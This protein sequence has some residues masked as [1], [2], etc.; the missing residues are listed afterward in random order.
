MQGCRHA[1]DVILRELRAVVGDDDRKPL[2]RALDADRDPRICGACRGEGVDGILHEVV[3]RDADF[4]GRDAHGELFGRCGR[5][6]ND[7]ALKARVALEEPD[8]LVDHVSQIGRDAVNG[9]GPCIESHALDNVRHSFGLRVDLREDALGHFGRERARGAEVAQS[10]NVGEDGADGLADFVREHRAQLS[11]KPDAQKSPVAFVRLLSLA[12]Q[13]PLVFQRPLELA[14][15]DPDHAAQKGRKAEAEEGCGEG[16]GGEEP[17]LL[18]EVAEA[19]FVHDV[20][21]ARA[22]GLE[23]SVGALEVGGDAPA[24]AVG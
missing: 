15:P 18:D 21:D 1:G 16:H 23:D 3:Q 5:L 8:R 24:H 14:G 20:V 12:A 4:K 11:E 10:L 9:I 7:F 22:E 17:V 2:L 6:Q 13:A 19:S